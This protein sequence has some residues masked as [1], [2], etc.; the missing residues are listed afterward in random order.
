MFTLY[1][2]VKQHSNEIFVLFANITHESHQGYFLFGKH[3][4]KSVFSVIISCD[5][6]HVYVKNVFSFTNCIDYLL[7]K[8]GTCN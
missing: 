6:I 2:L 1:F 5:S 3:V 7:Q 4:I 8:S